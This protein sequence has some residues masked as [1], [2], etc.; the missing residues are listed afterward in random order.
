M[1]NQIY[2]YIKKPLFSDLMKLRAFPE[3][4]KLAKVTPIFKSGKNKHLTSYRP[5]SVLPCFSKILERIMHNRVYE[6]LAKNNLLF[7][8]QF[9]FR[10]GHSTKH[11]LT[12][13]VNRIYN[14]FNENRHTL[15]V[16]TDLSKA[17]DTVNHNIL[18]KK[19]KTLWYRK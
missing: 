19:A 10:N 2:N 18:L 4:L 3:E 16:F 8:R 13:L 12:E 5:I 1:I 9:E 14:S 11:S 17:F 6:H 7:H 15:G